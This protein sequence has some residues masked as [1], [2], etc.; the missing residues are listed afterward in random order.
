MTRLEYSFP[1]VYF[2]SGLPSSSK[3]LLS[4]NFLLFA[5]TIQYILTYRLTVQI[6]K[7]FYIYNIADMKQSSLFWKENMFGI[8]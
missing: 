8:L 5:E 4:L 3:I 7:A 2:C 1:G 6:Q